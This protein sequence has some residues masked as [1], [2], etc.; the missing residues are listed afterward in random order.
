MQII[1]LIFNKQEIEKCVIVSG[2]GRS[3]HLYCIILGR[4]TILEWL[5]H[6]VKMEKERDS[7]DLMPTI[8]K[9]NQKNWFYAE[10]G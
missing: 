6:A 5:A 8:D 2:F 3:G 1:K 4:A 9:V 7:F 10:W